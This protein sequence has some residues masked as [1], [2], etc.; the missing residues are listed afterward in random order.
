MTCICLRKIWPFF[1]KELFIR[2]STLLSLA[3]EIKN[4]SDNFKKLKIALKTF[5]YSHTFYAL[6]EYFNR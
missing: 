4:L 5:L 1:E 2:E 3:T 6:D